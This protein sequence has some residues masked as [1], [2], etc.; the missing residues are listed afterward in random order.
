MQVSQN[1]S[2]VNNAVIGA[3]AIQSFRIAETPEF[4]HILSSSLYSNPKFA[5][6]REILCNAWDAHK[7]AGIERPV[8]VT[9]SDQKFVVKDFGSGIAPEDMTDIY[10]VYGSSTK[11]N[12]E[13]QIG[14]FGLGCKAPF[15]YVN[16]FEVI[17]CYKGTKTIYSLS[18]TSIDTDGK[19]AISTLIQVP[20][21]ETGLTVTI[22]HPNTSYFNRSTFEDYVKE[23]CRWT[24]QKVLL[25]Y[26]TCKIE[27]SDDFYASPEGF[28]ITSKPNYIE[29]SSYYVR[30]GGILYPFENSKYELGL[31]YE[32]LCPWG[33]AIILDAPPNSLDITPS[34]EKL[35]YS[36][37]TKNTLNSLCERF[38]RMYAKIRQEAAKVAVNYWMNCLDQNIY[39]T[40]IHS[41][42]DACLR[43]A[44]IH[45]Q[46]YYLYALAKI[47][48]LQAKSN[49]PDFYHSAYKCFKYR[50]SRDQLKW[51]YKHILKGVNL[52]NIY[53]FREKTVHSWSSLLE[54]ISPNV[55]LAPLEKKIYFFKSFN[56]IKKDEL[57]DMLLYKV[58]SKKQAQRDEEFF[59]SKGW[60]VDT[61]YLCFEKKVSEPKDKNLIPISYNIC[62]LSKCF[63]NWSEIIQVRYI[64]L[65]RISSIEK[66]KEFKY[67][68]F[69]DSVFS[70][71]TSEFLYKVQQCYTNV[72]VTRSK[73][74]YTYCLK[75][76]LKDLSEL[77]P[78]LEEEL[79]RDKQFISSCRN[80][81]IGSFKT[82]ITTTLD[83]EVI[84]CIC[85]IS[86][87]FTLISKYNLYPLFKNQYISKCLKTPK[88]ISK[89]Y[90]CYKSFCCKYGYENKF[91]NLP[92]SKQLKKFISKIVYSNL[93]FYKAPYEVHPNFRKA[94][95][96]FVEEH[97]LTRRN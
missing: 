92:M 64:T 59:K 90:I 5:V 97:I 84:N 27:Y 46:E 88:T 55:P 74:A 69:E 83:D 11:Q 34:R 79:M 85:N 82:K 53:M 66:L 78:V 62:S 70:R 1:T 54:E 31:I 72:V 24:G 25:D 8:E 67:V 20:T 7:A 47:K 58:T 33:S 89:K 75:Q 77:F 39:R 93:C 35:Q 37:K 15:A 41:F 49:K 95:V 80:D 50:K 2:N 86:P 81:F 56:H 96:K 71:F 26:G 16:T 60:E 38:I 73:A 63:N 40:K 14:G 23:L 22:R 4:F 3:K 87:L 10:C 43:Y 9:I 42:E 57:K 29:K 52:K 19:P 12:Q 6:V 76:G 68:F 17:S 45:K 30:Y 32:G 44:C 51:I 94:Y 91:R 61:S 21:D 48:A 65:N 18:K 13:N 28:V 36:D